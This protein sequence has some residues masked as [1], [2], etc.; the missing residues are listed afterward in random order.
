MEYWSLLDLD[1][2]E[3]EDEVLFNEAFEDPDCG[4]ETS[5][6]FSNTSLNFKAVSLTYILN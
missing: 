1:E 3:D 2:D 4:K 6:A 5:N